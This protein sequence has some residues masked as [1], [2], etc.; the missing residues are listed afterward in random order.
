MNQ[1]FFGTHL[2]SLVMFPLSFSISQIISLALFRYADLTVSSSIA[3]CLI[4]LT[5]ILWI[6]YASIITLLS[7]LSFLF[8]SLGFSFA[9]LLIS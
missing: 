5:L 7:P 6:L 2:K 4:L 8:H 9:Y 1:L 3:M